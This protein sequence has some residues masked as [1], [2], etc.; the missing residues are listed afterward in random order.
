MDD[1]FRLL[2]GGSRTALPRQQTL[3]ALIDWS[4]DYLDEAEQAMFRQLGVFSGGWTLEAAE[5]VVDVSGMDADPF[6][7]MANL[8]NKSLVV[9]DE[10]E[11]E[12]RFHL[13]ET[14]RQYARDKLFESGEGPASRDRHL[15][16][17]AGIVLAMN[18][19]GQTRAVPDLFA[20]TGSRKTIAWARQLKHE[21]DNVRLATEW[22]LDQDPELALDIA[23]RMPQYFLFE[24]SLESIQWLTEAQTR[25]AALPPSSGEAAELR[26]ERL[27]G[28]HVW[29]G[30][31]ELAEGRHPNAVETLKWAIDT[32]RE[33]GLE[34]LL[35]MALSLQSLSLF[36]L[37]DPR[38]F[39]TALEADRLTGRSG[40]RSSA[41]HVSFCDG[42]YCTAKR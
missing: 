41:R 9:V 31:L 34:V 8:V 11:D 3:R 22:A 24:G 27:V 17:F 7:L 28:S 37:S 10:G 42:P 33:N 13:L 32:A 15:A 40:G 1:R 25:V 5:A 6:D 14:I 26:T 35:A 36:F 29:L 38:A 23:L 4:Y 39:E 12:V 30:N 21:I 18:E 19:V 2:T 20:A 16:Y